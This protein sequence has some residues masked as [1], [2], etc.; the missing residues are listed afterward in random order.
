MPIDRIL[1][2]DPDD[3]NNLISTYTLSLYNSNIEVISMSN[4]MDAIEYLIDC[5]S[6]EYPQIISL[7]MNLPYLS[8]LE[9]LEWLSKSYYTG[10]IKIIVH[11]NSLDIVDRRDSL[12]YKDVIS[13]CVKPDDMEFLI[14]MIEN[15][16]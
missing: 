10:K 9:F 3:I 5:D 12:E 15:I 7:D 13:Y 14:K 8:G 1:L 2:I 6:S 11:A 16:K 4:G